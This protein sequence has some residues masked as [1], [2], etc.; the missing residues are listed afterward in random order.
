MKISSTTF[1]FK[2]GCPDFGRRELTG[3]NGYEVAVDCC[4]QCGAVK[5]TLIGKR[6]PVNPMVQGTV[7]YE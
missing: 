1:C 3:E 4:V 5:K 6:W 7:S 2:C